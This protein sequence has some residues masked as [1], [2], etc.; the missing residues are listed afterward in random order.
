MK[1]V[2]PQEIEVWYIL[3]A[4]RKEFSK[5]MIEKGK[6]QREIAKKLYITEAAVSQF[7]K[8]KRGGNLEFTEEI[9]KE[10]H[11]SVERLLKTG[12]IV[13]EFQFLC[14]KIRESKMLCDIHKKYGFTPPECEVGIVCLEENQ[15]GTPT[16]RNQ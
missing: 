4:L 11:E 10:V 15:N 9:K 5:I 13:Q 14:R 2:M 16:I 8:G 12:N 7:I 1:G 3:P 6:K